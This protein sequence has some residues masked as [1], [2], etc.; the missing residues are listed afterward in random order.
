[1]RMGWAGNVYVDWLNQNLFK[2]VFQ[3]AVIS[4][5]ASG[6]FDSIRWGIDEFQLPR[7]ISATQ[8]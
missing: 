4:G 8:S 6:V 1:M 7:G 5:D 2:V 3:S